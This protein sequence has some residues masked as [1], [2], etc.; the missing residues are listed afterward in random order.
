M[1]LA[2]SDVV[3]HDGKSG[4]CRVELGRGHGDVFGP[5]SFAQKRE[6]MRGFVTLPLRHAEGGF[7]VFLFLL[8][9]G[10]APP[11]TGHA[12]VVAACLL[13]R[14]LGG[15]QCRFRPG[16]LFRPVAV[17]HLEQVLLLRGYVG[18]QSVRFKPETGHVHAGEKLPL[19]HAVAFFR[20]KFRD[21][22]ALLEGQRNL[23][24][25]HVAVQP[26]P[27]FGRDGGGKA[28]VKSARGAEKNDGK[29]DGYLFHGGSLV[30]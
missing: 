20:K 2:E 18:A 23:A 4:S 3:L 22:S 14:G 15:A 7:G 24:D 21:A 30:A 17:L 27:F 9:H 11:Q 5:V 8:A 25:V 28:P 1:K 16:D 13:K 19:L 6:R 12:L 10:V 26:E 29:N